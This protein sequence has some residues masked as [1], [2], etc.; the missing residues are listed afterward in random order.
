VISVTGGPP[1]DDVLRREP[2]ALVCCEFKQATLMLRRDQAGALPSA[3][4]AGIDAK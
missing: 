2:D 1:K 3:H 4:R